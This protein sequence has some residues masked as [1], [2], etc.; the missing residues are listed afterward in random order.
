MDYNTDGTVAD[1]NRYATDDSDELNSSTL[2]AGASYGYDDDSELTSLAYTDGAGNLVAGYNLAYNDAGLVTTAYSYAD[3]SNTT[4]RTS[5][6]TTWATAQYNYDPTAQLSTTGSGDSTVN[7]VAYS[8]FAGAP[9][10]GGTTD[11]ETY[12]NDPN[13]NRTS[14]AGVSPASGSAS[15]T[16]RVLFDGTYYYLFDAAGN[17][18]AR[19]VN[20]TT[21]ALDSNATDITIYTWNNV[22]EL[23][24]VYSF[25][26]YSE[27][28]SAVEA[29]NL[30]DG[31]SLVAAYS[32]DAFGR[33]VAETAGGVTQNF[34]YDGANVALVLNSSGQVTERELY[35]AAVDAI[36]ASE[37]V[38]PVDSGPQPAG[39]V[40]WMLGDN[41]GTIRDVVQGVL[42]GSTMTAERRRSR[43]FRRLRQREP[44]G[45]LHEPPAPAVRFRRHAL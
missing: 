10:V 9:Q 43:H 33:V 4:D 24:G 34:V 19:Y 14:G 37:A 3:T 13:G 26:S 41:Q 12:T 39:T 6:Y 22:N 35:A 2:V 7:A 40:S 30:D 18:V 1:V 44:R 23:A 32:D 36:M 28:H 8:N 31:S 42:S 16:N 5:T 29:G 17:R 38:S 11:A 27:Y 15:A 45:G 21:K 20:D 25:S